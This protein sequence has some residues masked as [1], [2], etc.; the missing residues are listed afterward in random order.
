M[1]AYSA[2]SAFGEWGAFFVLYIC[3]PLFLLV[4]TYEVVSGLLHGKSLRQVNVETGIRYSDDCQKILGA[5]ESLYWMPYRLGASRQ[6]ERIS[7]D[8]FEEIEA[9][10]FGDKGWAAEVRLGEKIWRVRS[11]DAG[12]LGWKAD[13][14]SL[15][16]GQTFEIWVSPKPLYGVSKLVSAKG[17]MAGVL[18]LLSI[19]GAD[20]IGAA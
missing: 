9:H 5:V 11:F 19:V 7:F 20:K 6:N 15:Y 12:R 17:D 4:V 1:V 8:K 10:E 2:A 13:V 16:G 14:S 3:A 18:V